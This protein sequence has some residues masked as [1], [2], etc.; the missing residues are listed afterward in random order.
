MLLV[1]AV[2]R[3]MIVIRGVKFPE[4]ARDAPQDDGDYYE[5]VTRL[6]PGKL[7]PITAA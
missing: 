6:R 3:L 4:T 7:D 2:L 5:L 1:T